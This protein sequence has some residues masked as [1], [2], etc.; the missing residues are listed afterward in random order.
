MWYEIKDETKRI[1]VIRAKQAEETGADTVATACPFCLTMM[2]DGVSLNGDEEKLV[3][4]DLAEIVVKHLDWEP[5]G[6]VPA[7]P[8][9]ATAEDV[10]AS[11]DGAA[12]S[13]NGEA[14]QLAEPNDESGDAHGAASAAASALHGEEE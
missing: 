9:S 8:D 14:G 3:V 13:T 4:Q 6:S 7:A 11:T 12:S 2:T 5:A 1:N 10:A